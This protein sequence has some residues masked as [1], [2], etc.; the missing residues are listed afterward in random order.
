MAD[1]KLVIRKASRQKAFLKLGI[2]S[3]SGAGKTIGSL[4][5]AYGLMK[6]KYPDLSDVELWEKIVIVDS[7]NGS[8]E[9]YVGKYVKESNITIGEYA[10]LP[11]EAPFAPEKY[12]QA[13]GLAH[14]SGFEVCI[15]DSMT[16]MWMGTGGALERQSKIAARTGNSWSAWRE[17]TPEITTL[18][19]AILQ[20]PIHIIST[21]RSKTEHVQEKNDR[22]KTVVRK[23]GLN[24]IIRDGMEYEFTIF[25]EISAEHETFCSKDRTGIFDARY[26]KITPKI[27]Q[28]AMEWLESGADS[29]GD[30]IATGK[31][32]LSEQ[33]KE[34]KKIVIDLAKEL[35]GRENEDLMNEVKEFAPNGNPNSISNLDD[36]IDLAKTLEKMKQKKEQE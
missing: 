27:G 22:G 7:E 15:I 11:L 33:I 10:A 5:V 16:H 4:L 24:P 25:F 31:A 30:V 2:A 21:M 17:V 12:T 29:A 34:A 13:I 6:E 14:S 35:G 19:D 23:V 36:L 3:P 18:I 1:Q 26:F 8:G 9:L 32:S 20:T 28:E